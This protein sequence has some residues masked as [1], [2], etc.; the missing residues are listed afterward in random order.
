MVG[1]LVVRS[2]GCEPLVV[3][4]PHVRVVREE[5][6]QARSRGV[7]RHHV[8]GRVAPRVRVGVRVQV[9]SARI[10]GGE[11][12]GMASPGIRSITLIYTNI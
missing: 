7:A 5:Q 11:W 9:E 2:P 6:S 3:A 12:W 8:Q 1:W 4:R 10:G